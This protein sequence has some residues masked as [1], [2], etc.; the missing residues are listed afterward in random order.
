MGSSNKAVMAIPTKATSSIRSKA[1][2]DHRKAR[3]SPIT[4]VKIKDINGSIHPNNSNTKANMIKASST[5]KAHRPQLIGRASSSMAVAIQAKRATA[6][7]INQV[8][9]TNRR[10]AIRDSN[11]LHQ[12]DRMEAQEAKK[13]VA[14]WA[15]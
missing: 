12:E 11:T 10:K 8:P 9:A 2:V 7:R 4:A 14:S 6:K 1:T 3:A 5:A 13:T 15:P